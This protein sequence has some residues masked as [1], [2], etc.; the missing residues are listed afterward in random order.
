MLSRY[1]FLDAV[2]Y[3][4]VQNKTGPLL[5]LQTAAQHMIQYH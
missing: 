2:L 5:N 1:I 3:T 4:V